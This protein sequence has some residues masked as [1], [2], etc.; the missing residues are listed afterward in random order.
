MKLT[1]EP[2][3]IS[4]PLRTYKPGTVLLVLGLLSPVFEICNVRD[5]FPAIFE[6]HIL[7]IESPLSTN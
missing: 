1:G 3:H 5:I 4:N 7:K 2:E 6:I